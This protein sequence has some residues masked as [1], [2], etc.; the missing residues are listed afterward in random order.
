VIYILLYPNGPL[1][2][3]QCCAWVA[4]P[5]CDS[6][7]PQSDSAALATSARKKLNLSYS[8]TEVLRT[9]L[10]DLQH[11]VTQLS[12][13]IASPFIVQQVLYSILK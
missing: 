6:V 8:R 1:K 7:E 4:V 5:G 10:V 11:L 3:W 2:S 9:S 13:R 12:Q